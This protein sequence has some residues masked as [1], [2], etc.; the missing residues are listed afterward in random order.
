MASHA[1]NA[2][3]TAAVPTGLTASYVGGDTLKVDST[4]QLTAYFT[5][6]G[7]DATSI[8]W[9]F[10]LSDDLGTTWFD[11]LTEEVSAGAVTQLVAVRSLP[12]ANGTYV[13]YLPIP[14]VAHVRFAMKRTG[15]TAATTVHCSV[16]IGM[17]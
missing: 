14:A 10:Q 6:A 2:F 4:N 3:G 1:F 16:T 8:E 12:A 17:I 9:K 5:I 15:G 13:A 11:E 7:F